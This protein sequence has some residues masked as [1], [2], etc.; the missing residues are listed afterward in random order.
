MAR[1]LGLGKN[2]NRDRLDIVRD[3]LSAAL[4]RVRKTNIMYKA[5][6]SYHLLEKY[7]DS[8]LEA[9]LVECDGNF[10]FTTKR[11][12]LFLEQYNEYRERCNQIDESIDK[13]LEAKQMLEEMCFNEKKT[14]I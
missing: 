10:Y 4:V 1:D 6:L 5:N 14:S 2:K 8:L 7:L 9:G 12:G 3:M 11:G 13:A